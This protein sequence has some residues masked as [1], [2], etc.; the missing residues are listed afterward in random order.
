MA[1]VRSATPSAE[2]AAHPKFTGEAA[3]QVAVNQ[4]VQ[5]YLRFAHRSAHDC[6]S[7]YLKTVLILAWFAGSY[8]LLVFWA[9]TWWLAV[10]AALSLGF[11]MAAVGFNVQHD[12][13]HGAYSRHRW[14]NRLMARTIDLLGG[15]SFVWAHKHNT[16]H[17]TYANITGHDDDIDVGRLARLS[18]QQPWHR[19]HRAQHWYIWLLYAGLAIKWH[20]Y[21][22]FRDLIRGRIGPH[23][24]ARPTGW[25]L[26]VFI[27]GKVVS[28]GLAFVL[29]TFFHPFGW[30]LFF[31][32]LA[33][34]VHGVCLA[35]VFQLAHVVEEAAFPMPDAST[36]RL[37]RP[38][39]VHQVEVTTDF[40]RDNR[41]VSW[42]LGGLNYQ[43]EH[44]L[45]PKIC[46]VHYP[47]IARLVE[48]ACAK[49]GLRYHVHRTVSSG[50]A[51]HFRW[52]RRMSRRP[53]TGSATGIAG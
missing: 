52:L 13:G 32:V 40:A 36:G 23:R 38:W 2:R 8:L 17:H 46:H 53:A 49:H 21:D 22:D 3:F 34:S 31:Y 26:A 7:M 30:V 50:I 14:V 33:F 29:P 37:D 1:L 24:F 4:R 9:P 25:D 6:P 12:G 47:R 15:S 45:F 11:S 42:L 41:V 27:G 19:W 5:R 16:I 10:A 35:V 18:P 39:A 51:S 20:L 48:H 44:H 28:L 43:I